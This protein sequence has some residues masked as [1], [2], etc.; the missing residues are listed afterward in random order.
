MTLPYT[1]IIERGD[2]HWSARLLDRLQA[3]VI[4]DDESSALETALRVVS[5]PRLWQPLH[6]ILTN[7]ELPSQVRR[8]AA[9]VVRRLDW[10]PDTPRS[11]VLQWWRDGDFLLRKHALFCMDLCLQDIVVEVASDPTHELHATAI[12]QMEFFFD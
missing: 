9:S 8:A 5:D 7:R 10:Q 3:P 11:L 4:S 2:R 1:D 12:L 6:S